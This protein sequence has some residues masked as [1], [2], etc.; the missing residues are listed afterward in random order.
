M[1]CS[2]HFVD[3]NFDNLPTLFERNATKRFSFVSPE[4][5]KRKRKFPRPENR[6]LPSVEEL[7]GGTSSLATL[8]TV[9]VNNKSG[10]Y[11]HEGDI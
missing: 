5:R 10:C 4:K 6:T 8:D 7:Q 11:F 2:C 9:S 1:I 3:E